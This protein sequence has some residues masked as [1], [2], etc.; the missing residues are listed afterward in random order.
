MSGIDNRSLVAKAD[1]ALSDLTAGGGIL[2]PE[3][4]KKFMR[5]LTTYSALLG[6]CTF[7]PMGAPTRRVSRVKFGSRILRAGT[8]ATALDAADRVKPDLGYVDLV[9]QLFKAEVW[10]DD[11][12]LEDN[13]EKGDFKQ[14]VMDL[15]AERVAVDMEEVALKGDTASADPCL[16]KLNGL[17]KTATSHVVAAGGALFLK[18]LAKSMMKALPAEFKRNKKELRYIVSVDSETNYRDSLA[19]RGTV[20]GDKHLEED[21]PVLYNGAPIVGVPLVPENLGAGQN[22]SVA[23]LTHPKNAYVGMYRQIRIETDRDVSAGVLKVVASLRF[24]VKWADESGVVKAT[25]VGL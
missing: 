23:L 18:P 19:D 12:V 5:S 11:E 4:A 10:L 2:Q 14:L 9:A 24:D 17:I 15:L 16:A 13:I 20:A 7:V 8:E 22:Q 6:M 25:A 1:L 21:A 3:M